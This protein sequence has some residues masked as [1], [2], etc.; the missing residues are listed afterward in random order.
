MTQKTKTP[1]L[2]T[3]RAILS[4]PN[5]FEPRAV[6]DGEPKYSCS[7]VFA[8]DADLSMLKTAAM[9]CAREKWLGEAESMIRSGGIHMPFRSDGE[10]KGYGEGTTFINC[11]TKMKPGVVSRFKD[12]ETGK[13][14]LITDPEEIYPGCVVWATVRTY[15]WDYQGMK[16]GVSFGL[17]NIQ[18]LDDGPRLD[19]RTQANEDFEADL[20]EEPAGLEEFL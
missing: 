17:G 3:P 7:L 4:F 18:K 6:G 15:A 11:S 10:A 2:K 13:P 8:A 1:L 20:T 16:K 14:Q 9:N 12:P 19:S 5:L